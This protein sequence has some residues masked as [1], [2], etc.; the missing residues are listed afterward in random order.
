MRIVKVIKINMMALLALPLLL[1]ATVAQ[2]AA[3]A[4]KKALGQT[5]QEVFYIKCL[6]L[7]TLNAI[8]LTMLRL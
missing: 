4:M 8:I 5:V 2:M 1:L 6:T 3:K 7:S